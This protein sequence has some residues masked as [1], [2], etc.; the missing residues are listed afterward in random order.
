MDLA[1]E[2]GAHDENHGCNNV[3]MVE[4]WLPFSSRTSLPRDAFSSRRHPHPAP[5]LK[6]AG[7]LLIFR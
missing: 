7:R 4:L 2:S 1:P 3:D 5:Y 6:R